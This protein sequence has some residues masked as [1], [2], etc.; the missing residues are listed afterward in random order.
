M[1]GL[2]DYIDYY[3]NSKNEDWMID[4][5]GSD[6]FKKTIIEQE[7]DNI[8]FCFLAWR[9]TIKTPQLLGVLPKKGNL[10]IYEGPV[11][12]AGTTP[13]KAKNALLKLEI[14]FKTTLNL[15]QS[16]KKDNSRSIGQIDFPFFNIEAGAVL[17]SD[18]PRNGS[19]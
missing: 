17:L 12:L 7:G 1:F 6:T 5:E 10:I 3:I 8:W 11:D 13:Y 2:L 9:N 16:E 4:S 14:D 18:I 15:F 19:T